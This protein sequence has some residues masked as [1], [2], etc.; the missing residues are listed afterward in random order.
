[1]SAAWR[2]PLNAPDHLPALP[3]AVEVAAYRIIT[4]AITNAVRHSGA[5]RIEIT[6]GV[7][8][9]AGLSIEVRDDGT[10]QLAGWQPGVGV[11]SMRERAAELGGSCRFEASP[12]GGGQVI[13]LLPVDG[14]PSPAQATLRT[15]LARPPH[16]EMTPAPT[17]VSA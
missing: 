9:G 11:T 2:S 7:A 14:R 13:A 17:E 4:E 8:A 1:M 12:G 6:L 16:G 15:D 3:A 10:G 5:G